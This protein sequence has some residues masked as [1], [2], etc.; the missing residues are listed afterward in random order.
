MHM[1]ETKTVVDAASCHSVSCSFQGLYL[2]FCQIEFL[3]RTN[4]V[5]L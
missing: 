5:S 1:V 2:P 3:T 4:K